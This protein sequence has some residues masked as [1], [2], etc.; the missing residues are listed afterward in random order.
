MKLKYIRWAKYVASKGEI[1][2]AAFSILVPKPKRKRTIW[3]LGADGR[4]LLKWILKT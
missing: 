3:D 4:I 1:K 2:N